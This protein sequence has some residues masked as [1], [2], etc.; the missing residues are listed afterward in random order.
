MQELLGKTIA[1]VTTAAVELESGEKIARLGSIT[2]DDG[3][4]LVLRAVELDAPLDELRELVSGLGVE[5]LFVPAPR[6]KPGADDE[7][8]D[9][10]G[11]LREERRRREAGPCLPADLKRA[12]LPV[13]VETEAA[14]AT[15]PNPRPA[16]RGRCKAE[17][18]S[19][20]G[21]E[22]SG[23]CFECAEELA[24]LLE[25][26]GMDPAGAWKGGSR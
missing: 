15:L 16:K 8:G 14:P 24:C 18:C 2:F 23:Y 11:Y 9:A 17:G 5:G 1:G 12:G 13:A 20:V 4:R 21:I 6:F 26:E 10:R 7:H 22:A 25:A 3:S 19:R